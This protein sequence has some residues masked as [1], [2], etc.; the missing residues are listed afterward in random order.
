MK[1]SRRKG[2]TLIELLIVVAIIGILAAIAI[3]N[4]L[5]AQTRAK[6][7]RASADLRTMATG[8]ALYQTDNNTFPLANWYALA[9]TPP[10]LRP[11]MPDTLE[12]LSTPVEY[13]RDVSFRD[14]FR[15]TAR[16][17]NPTTTGAINPSEMDIAQIYKY[18]ARNEFGMADWINDTDPEDRPTWYILESVG[19]DG[20]YHN[21]S[22]WLTSTY[23]V[24]RAHQMI[25]DPTNGTV[26]RGSIWRVSGAQKGL[27]KAFFEAASQKYGS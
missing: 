12:R 26:S 13:V 25:Y 7:A 21:L 9:L 19:P 6:A 24:P 3:P 23:N 17:P 8:L 15:V 4:F 11:A 16:Y 14:P 5:Q 1:L 22:G 18:T 20:H 10:S 2:F 27:G